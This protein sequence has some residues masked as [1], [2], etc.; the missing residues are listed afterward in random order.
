MG[1][2]FLV[3]ASAAV[4]RALVGPSRAAT[5]VA[6]TGSATYLAVEDDAS[7]TICVAS[8]TAVRVPCALVLG[9][10]STA[11]ELPVGTIGTVGR[12]LV[13]VNASAYRVARWWRPATV[14]PVAGEPARLRAAVAALT[15]LVADPLDAAGRA[16][17]GPLVQALST[18][19]PVRPAVARLLGRGPGLT[20]TGDDVLAGALVTLSA[21]A[22]RAAA[23]LAAAVTESAPAATT[24]VSAALLRH[25]ARGE[26]IPELADLLAAV[27]GGRDT[28]G[29]ARAAGALLAVGHCSG[30]GLVHG[31]ILGLAV[32]SRQ[33][34]YLGAPA[35]ATL[36]GMR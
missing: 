6:A 34:P 20:P 28:G 1:R 21:F 22:P 14:R 11:P 36:V 15:G 9:P 4:E 2:P 8:P 30:A 33:T 24:A 23:P 10:D 25:A 5:V 17:A 27:A 12:G 16:A 18:G 35:V 13:S 19:T 26:C 32:A 29:L 3:A 31:V 7:T